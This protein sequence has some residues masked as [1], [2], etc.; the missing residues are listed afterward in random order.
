M[1]KICFFTCET[2]LVGHAAVRLLIDT[3]D[4]T[5]A[6]LQR[7]GLNGGWAHGRHI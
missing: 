2:P 7:R 6:F 5:F 4:V 3:T 1:K